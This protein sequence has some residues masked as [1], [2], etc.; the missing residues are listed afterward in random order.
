MIESSK[1]KGQSKGIKIPKN[2]RSTPAWL[3]KYERARVIGTRALQISKNSPIYVAPSIKIT[4]KL[5]RKPPTQLLLL[6]KNYMKIKS[7]LLLEDIYQ[8]ETLKIGSYRS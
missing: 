1:F 6:N 8:T 5:Q 7:P 4:L 3:T 2:Q